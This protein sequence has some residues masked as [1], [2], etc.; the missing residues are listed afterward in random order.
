MSDSELTSLRQLDLFSL[1]YI[2]SFQYC[3]EQTSGLLAALKLGVDFQNLDQLGYSGA[4]NFQTLFLG[5]NDRISA[6]EVFYTQD[7]VT[8]LIVE[9]VQD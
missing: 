7:K 8:G 1:S 2:T 5:Q 3:I 9:V 4:C 6:L